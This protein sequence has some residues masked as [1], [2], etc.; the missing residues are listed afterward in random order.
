MRIK[1][2]FKAPDATVEEHADDVQ[3]SLLVSL[4]TGHLLVTPDDAQL[5]AESK[6]CVV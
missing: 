4:V 5:K 2:Q 3:H 6:S 1:A